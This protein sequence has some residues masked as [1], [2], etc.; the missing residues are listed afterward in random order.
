MSAAIEYPHPYAISVDEFLRM[1]EA[2]IFAPEARLELIEGGI[3]EMAP[4]GSPHAGAVNSLTELFIHLAYGLAT[5]TVQN[6]FIADDISMPQPDLLLAKPRADRYSKSHPTP[7]DILLLIEV[8][9]TTLRFDLRRKAPFYAR[10]GIAEVWVVDVNDRV[11]HMFRE[12]SASGYRTALTAAVG[13]KVAPTALPQVEITV[14]DIFRD[15]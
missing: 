4:I 14:A 3:L 7:A 15:G 11:V 9:D 2:G 10:R 6:P 12:P 1:G 13:D 5:V 8:A